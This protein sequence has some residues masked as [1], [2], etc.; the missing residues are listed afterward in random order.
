VWVL[1]SAHSQGW[2]C[3][4]TTA[5]HSKRSEESLFDVQSTMFKD[6]QDEAERLERKRV[7]EGNL[8][9]KNELR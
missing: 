3:Y 1:Q 9:L 7:A 8:K 4:A 5:R 2:L 6:I